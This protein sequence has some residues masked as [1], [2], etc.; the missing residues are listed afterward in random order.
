MPMHL[1]SVYPLIRTDFYDF[2][3]EIGDMADIQ[4]MYK[5]AGLEGL[6]AGGVNPYSLFEFIKTYISEEFAKSK[7]LYF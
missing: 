4:D 5:I 2:V 3:L 6:L 7:S 1:K